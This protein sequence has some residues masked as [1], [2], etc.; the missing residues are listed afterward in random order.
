VDGD[1]AVAI[2]SLQGREGDTFAEDLFRREGADRLRSGEFSVAEN[3][4]GI[5]QN[6]IN[7]Y[8]SRL[9]ALRALFESSRDEISRRQFEIFA[10]GILRDQTAIQSVSWV[11]RVTRAERT[12]RERAAINDGIPSYQIKAVGLGP[13]GSLAPSPER[14]EYFPIFYSTEKPKTSPV[15]GI[16]LASEGKRR[17]TLERAGRN[18]QPATFADFRLHTGVGDRFGFIVVLP[19]YRQDVPSDTEEERKR[20]L[21]GFVQ[22]AFQT[23]VM[24]E[25][26]LAAAPKPVGVDVFLFSTSVDPT[27]PPVNIYASGLRATP[28]QPAAQAT[29]MAGTHWSS[30]LRAG[31]GRWT[32]VAVPAPSE[33]FGIGHDRA[34]IILIAGLL[35]S[36]I[37]VAYLWA[38]GR[39]ARRVE[40]LALTDPLTGLANRR[41]FLEGLTLAFA[42]SRRSASPF[43]VLFVDL[44]D[45]KDVNDTL[46]HAFG[47][48]LLATG[49]GAT[50]EYRQTD[51][52]RSALWRR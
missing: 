43:A 22:G 21:I 15:F 49:R 45:F 32:L 27:A 30:E 51:R 31:D 17:E 42:A 52:P 9:F 10:E 13:D 39:N 14:D 6:G 40:G 48:A 1:V 3:Q 41:A 50:Q 23:S 44:D 11:P 35:V 33:S 29:L 25:T 18:N 16:D 38:S 34:W 19:M 47:D 5:L 37:V 26:I 4:S 7:Q 2:Y 28:L 20:N 46:G 36:G 12:A 24:I 8:L